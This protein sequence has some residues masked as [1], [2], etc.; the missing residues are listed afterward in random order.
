M[1]VTLLMLGRLALA[2]QAGNVSGLPRGIAALRGW[3]IER[4]SRV[5]F[6]GDG[7]G[8]IALVPSREMPLFDVS[9]RLLLN[10]LGRLQGRCGHILGP[11]HVVA[12]LGMFHEALF[13]IG[14]SLVPVLLVV[15]IVGFLRGLV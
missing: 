15:G 3:K 2:L 12:Q 9:R 4:F 6:L 7:V 1:L 14:N 8:C 13:L 5:V 11:G 10:F